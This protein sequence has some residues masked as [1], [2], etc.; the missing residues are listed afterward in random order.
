MKVNLIKDTKGKVVASFED[1]PSGKPSIQ[2][3]LSNGELLHTVDAVA[4]YKTD[5]AAFYRQ[6]SN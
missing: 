5:I 6:H 4:D 2:P 1:A 3:V